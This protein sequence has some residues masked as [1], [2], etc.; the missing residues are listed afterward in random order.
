M[1]DVF[2]A[3]TKGRTDDSQEYIFEF[4]KDDLV[5]L[6]QE[7]IDAVIRK[8]Y[9]WVWDTTNLYLEHFGYDSVDPEPITSIF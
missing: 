8:D 1:D 2:E 7:K 6:A 4:L 5:N 3:G 9:D